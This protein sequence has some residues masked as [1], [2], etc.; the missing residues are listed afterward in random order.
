[1]ATERP[2]YTAA[3]EGGEIVFTPPYMSYANHY[4]LTT[5]SQLQP[6]GET[7]FAYDIKMGDIQTLVSG[8]GQ[9]DRE[10]IMIYDGSGTVIGSTNADYLGGDLYASPEE[11]DRAADEARA[12][13]EAAAAGEER[14]KAEDKLNSAEA[15]HA[16]RG[17]STRAL[18]GCAAPAAGRSRSPLTARSTSAAS[19][20]RGSSAF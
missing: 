6:D 7:V 10:Q 4:I 17:P 3:V 19:G 8:A 9:F 2:W 16:F 15:F 5:I 11:A 18:P 13:L 20:R 1:M 12:E 14:A